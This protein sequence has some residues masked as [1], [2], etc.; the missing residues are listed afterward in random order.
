MANIEVHKFGGTSLGSAERFEAAATLI[1][2][3]RK[4][5]GIIVVA[6]AMSGVTDDLVDAAKGALA[7]D[8]KGALERIETLEAR[9]L[10]ILDRLGG[11]ESTGGEISGLCDE[12][13]DLFSGVFMLGEFTDRT[14]DRIISTGEKLSVRLF[15]FA[16][17]KTGIPAVPLDADAFL[18]TDGRFGNADPVGGVADRTISA[19]L[20]PHLEAGTVPV[21]T[22]FCGRAPNGDTTTLGRGGSDLSATYIAAA[23]GADEVTIWTD[24]D[25]VYSAD[26]GVVPEA[27]VIP[28]LNFREAAEVSFYGAKV[29]HQRSMIPVISSG[30]PVRIRNSFAPESPGTKVNGKFTPGSHP[31]KAISAVRGHCLFSVEGKGMAGVPG[32]AARIFGALASRCISV[33]MISQSSSESTICLAVPEEHALDT[34]RTL[35]SEFQQDMCR[36]L[37]DEIVVRRHVCLV[38]AVGLGMANTPGVASRVFRALGRRRINV[39]AIAQGS[40]ELNISLAVDHHQVDEALRAVHGEF[41]LDRLD[42][43]EV[44][45]RRLDM[46]LLGCGNIGQALV[47]ILR[48][49]TAHIKERFGLT[50]NLVCVSDSSGYLF[51]PGGLS[52]ERISSLVRGKAD[53]MS[54]ADMDGGVRAD[55][56][57][58]LKEVLSYRLA[59]PVLVDVSSADD[60]NEAFGAAFSL[61]CDVVTANKK[62]LAGP[63]ETY[64]GLIEEAASTDRILKAEATVGAGLPVIDTL[65]VLLAAGDRLTR[66]KGSLSGTLGYLMGQL[67]T[68]TP[69]SEA[70][71][72][73]REAGFTEPDPVED[74]C[75]I[76]VARKAIILGRLSGLVRSNDPVEFEG[77]VDSSLAGLDFSTL[78]EELRKLDDPFK[79]RI[80]EARD[81]DLVLRYLAVIKPGIIEVGP[82]SVPADSPFSMLRGTDNMIVFESE[83]YRDRPLVIT[84]PGAGIDVTAMGVLGD[85]LRVAAERR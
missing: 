66:F 23:I 68:G 63:L 9:H 83:R 28:Q 58:M 6:S 8:R 57:S 14:M 39:L 76:D 12:L 2:D 38:A 41:G 21:V 18:E 70:V 84:G 61:G 36:G 49:Q 40:S 50:P 51:E 37:I 82:A 60:S 27:R 85:I 29:L 30:I 5:A 77:L 47:G 7:A 80:S 24:V 52:D 31:V 67:E 65:E 46:I 45:T 54:I 73:A 26:P 4:S 35:K 62:P 72:L 59:R 22:G 79:R 64:N 55:S 81:K 34:E 15:A 43:G 56:I 13:R 53:S 74:L 10:E 42:T 44:S 3:A 48:E 11:N 25:G 19:E 16:L 33:T 78:M 71:S 32:V 17:E 20:T 1:G 69:F 75:G